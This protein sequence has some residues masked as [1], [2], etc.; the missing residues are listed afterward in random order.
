MSPT[1]NNRLQLHRWWWMCIRFSSSNLPG[2]LA[3]RW[4]S[5]CQ[6]WNPWNAIYP[7]WKCFV[8]WIIDLSTNS[9]STHPFLQRTRFQWREIARVHTQGIVELIA[10]VIKVHNRFCYPHVAN[11]LLGSECNF[12]RLDNVRFK[13]HNTIKN[14]KSICLIWWRDF[15][16][17]LKPFPMASWRT[18]WFASTTFEMVSCWH[19]EV[20]L[21]FNN[22]ENNCDEPCQNQL[23][24]V[25]VVAVNFWLELHS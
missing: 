18:E 19:N 20:W 8:L 2:S 11:F 6:F 21:N 3:S 22:T 12:P 10:E 7:V 13:I 24:G 5:L 9:S 15:Q 25:H 17:E 14:E 4:N 23:K 1:G 16:V